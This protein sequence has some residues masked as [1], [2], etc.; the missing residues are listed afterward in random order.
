MHEPMGAIHQG[1]LHRG[2]QQVARDLRSTDIVEHTR[3][4]ANTLKG[5]SV[6]SQRQFVLG[7]PI[8]KVED[9]T[10]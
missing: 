3:Y 10:R 9:R 2:T 1:R 7:S 5:V 6:V 4:Q 8:N